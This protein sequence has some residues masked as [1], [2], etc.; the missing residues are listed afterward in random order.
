[1]KFTRRQIIKALGALPL[2]GLFRSSKQPKIQYQMEM[3]A[4]RMNDGVVWIDEARGPL[5]GVSD[6]G[7]LELDRRITATEIRTAQGFLSEQYGAR[8]GRAMKLDLDEMVIRAALRLPTRP[9]SR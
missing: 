8:I 9:A 1:M 3:R 6:S 5:D 4:T 7:I 2:V